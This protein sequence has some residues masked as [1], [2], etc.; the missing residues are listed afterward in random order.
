M[1][2]TAV[3]RTFVLY[4][5]HRTVTAV[6]MRLVVF[7]RCSG[8]KYLGEGK[9][10][11]EAEYES[12]I[13]GLRAA[14]KLSIKQIV[15]KG[16]SMLVIQQV[17]PYPPPPLSSRHNRYY[18][19]RRNDAPSHPLAFFPPQLFG[20]VPDGSPCFCLFCGR[21]LVLDGRGYRLP[22]LIPI[23]KVCGWP[24]CARRA[25]CDCDAHSRELLF[26]R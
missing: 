3:T 15:V 22:L 17:R 8:Y 13:L 4:L 26:W 20:H 16:D 9:T 21:G 14:V 18:L 1:F 7:R 19:T 2:P 12:V 24:C 6:P 25:R 10:N 11:N 5:H 23:M